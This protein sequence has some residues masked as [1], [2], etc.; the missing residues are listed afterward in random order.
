MFRNEIFLE[1][2]VTQA[3][4]TKISEDVPILST[5]VVTPFWFQVLSRN[6][7]EIHHPDNVGHMCQVG[8]EYVVSMRSAYLILG[9]KYTVSMHI[10]CLILG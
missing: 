7:V 2:H 10:V 3:R 8:Y 6:K 5:T 4:W 1:R 9:Y